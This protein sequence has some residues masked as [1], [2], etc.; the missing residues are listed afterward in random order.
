[1]GMVR[2]VHA[3]V[4]GA[5]VDVAVDGQVVASAIAY[6]SASDYV[7]VTLGDHQIQVFEAGTQTILWEQSLT[8]TTD[9]L[10]LIASSASAPTF[11]EFI[12]N[13]DPSA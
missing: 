6:G 8:S 1:M 5:N 4:G 3:I 10:T 7:S 9:P 11:V 2:F 13:V 12:E